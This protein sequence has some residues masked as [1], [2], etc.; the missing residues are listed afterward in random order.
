[1]I[2]FPTS[3][4]KYVE[5]Y[6]QE[7]LG[8]SAERAF[9]DCMNEFKRKLYD[10]ALEHLRAKVKAENESREQDGPTIYL[11]PDKDSK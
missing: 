6:C 11:M 8:K 1:M 2:L 3:F 7:V 4:P 10:S 9:E 5:D